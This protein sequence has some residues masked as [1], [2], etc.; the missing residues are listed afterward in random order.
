MT[1]NEVRELIRQ[2]ELVYPVVRLVDPAETT[3]WTVDGTGELC[4]S[5]CCF[6]IWGRE[7]RCANCSSMRA[8]KGHATIDKYEV[9]DRDAYHIT[10]K[11][12]RVDGRDYVLEIVSKFEDRNDLFLLF[13]KEMKRRRI[14]ES[15]ADDFECVNY[16]DLQSGDE[17]NTLSVYR[18]SENLA[19]TVP[20]WAQEQNFSRKMELAA[21]YAVIP[22]DRE[23]FLSQVRFETLLPNL[24][25][26]GVYFIDFRMNIT[27]TVNDY[28]MKFHA[29]Q[30]ENG[31]L[32]GFVAGCHCIASETKNSLSYKKSAIKSI[33]DVVMA[34]FWHE[35]LYENGRLK[36][37]YYSDEMRAM[38]GYGPDEFPNT[39]ETLVEHLHPD[40]RQMMLDAAIAAGTGKIPAYDVE[41]RI[42]HADGRYMWVNATGKLIKND[43]GKPEGMYGAVI[44]ISD[45]KL[46]QRDMEIIDVLTSEYTGVYFVDLKTG[47]ATPYSMIESVA[48]EIGG[49]LQG[50]MKYVD[51]YRMCVDTLVDSE[52]RA[53]MLAAGTVGNIMKELRTKKTFITIY[54]DI[55]GRYCEMKFIKMGNA[56]G[57]PDAVALCFSI[58]DEEFRAKEEAAQRLQRNLDIIG[59]LASEYSSVYYID[60]DT[61]ELD[62]Y[63]MNE[64]TESEFGRVLRDGIGYSE[65]F[66]IYVD[67][68]VH[69][70]DREMMRKAGSIYNILDQLSDKKTFI[71][72]YRDAEGHH[73]EMKFI[74]VGDDELPKAVTLGF[75]EAEG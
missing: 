1:I 55:E 61:N 67:T 31:T 10:S 23:M 18:T 65:A 58:K 66:R 68:F 7:C 24:E 59:I 40:D 53:M 60:M 49:A 74:K 75:S 69:P 43:N 16:V 19:N 14:I 22:E 70:E 13:E 20:G 28:Q 41:Y 57:V 17:A 3:V 8:C 35:E 39:L 54:K 2:L 4:P 34:A 73:C 9:F 6:S 44:D 72:R 50:G 37:I 26:T 33:K 63:T 46:K 64:Q 56:Q 30:D 15:L 36:A 48:S 5:D 27:G 45:R 32:I 25:K 29:D 52:Y 38:L 51:V 71:T 47:E 42:R 62:T 11:Y 21:A 12:L